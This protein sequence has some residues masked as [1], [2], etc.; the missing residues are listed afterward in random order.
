[1]TISIGIIAEDESDID[2]IDVLIQ[3][4]AGHRRYGIK[5]FLGRGSGRIKS[6]CFAWASHLKLLRCSVLIVV[7][8]SDSNNPALLRQLLL[9][10]IGVCP[11]QRH[12]IVI[13]VREIEAWLLADH[14]AIQRA[15]GIKQPIKLVANP[16]VIFKPKE[17]LA[18]LIAAKSRREKIYINTIHNKKIAKQA[19]IKQLRRCAS[20]YPFERFVATELA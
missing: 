15:L 3:K 18:H 10:A 13:P 9:D 20:F 16:E 2:V 17:Y 6:K 7:V 11:I 1:M 5:Q 4:I 12:T 14:N 19:S 8:D